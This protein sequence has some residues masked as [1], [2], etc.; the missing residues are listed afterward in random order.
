M[1]SASESPVKLLVKSSVDVDPV[2]IY[3]NVERFL[4][5]LEPT[6]KQTGDSPKK[7]N[8]SPQKALIPVISVQIGLHLDKILSWL[9]HALGKLKRL[10]N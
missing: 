9:S 8:L 7:L 10:Y 4:P 1:R 5:R 3:L 6:F 2:L